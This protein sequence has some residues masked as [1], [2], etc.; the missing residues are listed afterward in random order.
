MHVFPPYTKHAIQIA[1]SLIFIGFPQIEMFRRNE[2]A[3]RFL[4]RNETEIYFTENSTK[5]NVLKN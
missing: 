5:Q 1:V 3:S 4:S 2:M